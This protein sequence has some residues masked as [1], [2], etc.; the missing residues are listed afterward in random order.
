MQDIGKKINWFGWILFN[1]NIPYISPIVIKRRQKKLRKIS[2][3]YSKLLS[4]NNEFI[5]LTEIKKNLEDE[6]FSE[7][8]NNYSPLIFNNALKF[9]KLICK[10]YFLKTIYTRKSYYPSLNTELLYSYGNNKSKLIYPLPSRYRNFL[11]KYDIEFNDFLSDIYWYSSIFMFFLLG[12]FYGFKNI[13]ACLYS[14]FFVSKTRDNFVYFYNITQNC[15]PKNDNLNTYSNLITWY[16]NKNINPSNTICHNIKDIDDIIINSYKISY[17]NPIEYLDNFKNIFQYSKWLVKASFLCFIDIF[18]GRWWHPL[19]FYESV[20][21]SMFRL[22]NKENIASEY[23]FNNSNYIFR[24]MWTYEAEKT[25]KIIMAFYSTNLR[26][27]NLKNMEKIL[28]HYYIRE[29]TW[30]NYYLWDKYDNDYFKKTLINKTNFEIKG[31]IPFTNGKNFITKKSTKFLS[32]FDIQPTRDIF[33]KTIVDRYDDYYKV[34]NIINFLN[35][36][37]TLIKFDLEINIKR[38]RDIGSLAH[39]FYRNFM[40][41]IDKIDKINIINSD[42]S[43]Y[44][45]I[46]KSVGVISIPFTSTAHIANQLKIPSIYYD[47]SRLIE[48]DDPSLHNI[49]LVNSLN[50]LENWVQ[51]IF[52]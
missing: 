51:E 34:D 36:I 12:L 48:S 25:S 6:V 33:Y 21:A 17:K 45:M 28:P 50:S 47:P 29:S 3:G 46:N 5:P 11:K 39:P 14:L 8:D 19:L 10:H 7:T 23:Y 41:K 16:I 15:L 1:K 9:S 49:Q 31:Y 20:N 30:P 37:L 18:R 26:E 43:A 38:K 4:K 2:R 27:I 24:P 22:Q 42:V 40:K 13:A 32:V 35:D 52:K 44:E